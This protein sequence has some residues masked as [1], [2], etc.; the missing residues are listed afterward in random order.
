[1]NLTKAEQLKNIIKKID[2]EEIKNFPE[3][4]KSQTLKKIFYQS[5]RA[6]NSDDE[7][8]VENLATKIAYSL[9]N[10]ANKTGYI[11]DDEKK[12]NYLAISKELFENTVGYYEKEVEK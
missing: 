10:L 4:A 8:E 3:F 5:K 2:L 6:I 1:M 9:Y 11:K 12:Q 7:K